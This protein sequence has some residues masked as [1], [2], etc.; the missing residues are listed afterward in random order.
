LL[1]DAVDGLAPAV[2]QKAHVGRKVFGFGAGVPVKQRRHAFSAEKF[3]QQPVTPGSFV[4]TRP[5]PSGPWAQAKSKLSKADFWVWQVRRVIAPGEPVP[6]HKK[7]AAGHVYVSQIFEP[8]EKSGKGRW[9]PIFT[10]DRTVYMRTAEEKA[11]RKRRRL[12]GTS[13]RIIAEA[14]EASS[15]D[16][17][18]RKPV[19]CFLRPENII[20]GG[21]ACTARGAVP[22]DVQRYALLQLALV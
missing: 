21:F 19:C 1:D 3:A 13:K 20:G 16:E 7:P 18:I 9:T 6:G 14:H 12:W 11:R 22:D 15:D 10:K 4:M 8:K 17:D 5:A 2:S